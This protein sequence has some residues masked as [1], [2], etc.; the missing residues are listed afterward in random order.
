MKIK[1]SVYAYI[2]SMRLYY[3]F[4]EWRFWLY[5]G[6]PFLMN[7]LILAT[8]LSKQ[9]YTYIFPPKAAP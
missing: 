9:L 6:I 1:K 4:M 7:S 2:K 8:V 5:F 3:A